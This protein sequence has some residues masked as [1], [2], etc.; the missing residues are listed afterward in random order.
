MEFVI[1]VLTLSMHHC[2]WFRTY[3]DSTIYFN[4]SRFNAIYRNRYFVIFIVC[5]C[6]RAHLALAFVKTIAIAMC[7]RLS[8]LLYSKSHSINHHDWNELTISENEIIWAGVC[9]LVNA[10]DDSDLNWCVMLSK[11]V[12]YTKFITLSTLT[13]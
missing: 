6:V 9:S 11:S 1:L 8:L 5:V 2:K 4:W 13:M 12:F 7:V 10:L 3:S